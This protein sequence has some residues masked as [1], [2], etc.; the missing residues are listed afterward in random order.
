M[1]THHITASHAASTSAEKP[2][3][4]SRDLFTQRTLAEGGRHGVTN[5]RRVRRPVETEVIVA[6][7]ALVGTIITALLYFLSSTRNTQ[8][9]SRNAAELALAEQRRDLET[10]R[11]ATAEE[12]QQL[13]ELRDTRLEEMAN[14]LGSARMSLAEERQRRKELET[15]VEALGRR[16]AILDEQLAQYRRRLTELGEQV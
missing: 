6:L 10:A 14:Q 13:L 11:A 2:A 16:I 12:R 1:K 8:V 7:F 9:Q 5:H 15:E 4:L 3:T